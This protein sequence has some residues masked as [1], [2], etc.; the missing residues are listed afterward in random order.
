MDRPASVTV[1]SVVLVGWAAVAILGAVLL[2]ADPTAVEVMKERPVA[3]FLLFTGPLIMLVS[4]LAIWTGSNWGRVLYV[5]WGIFNFGLAR[6]FTPFSWAEFVP[7][8]VFAIL[9]FF[10]F[11]PEAKAYFNG[12]S[13]AAES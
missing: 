1:I 11:R 3:V 8:A 13:A 10:L 2:L 6:L 7:L 9:V 5:V 4:G 12:T